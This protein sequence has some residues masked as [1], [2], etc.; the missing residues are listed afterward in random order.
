[1]INYP[2]DKWPKTEP[3]KLKI[4]S[5]LTSLMTKRNMKHGAST[6]ENPEN[7]PKVNTSSSLKIY[8]QSIRQKSILR[9]FEH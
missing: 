9:T 2:K 8:S 1:M 3:N 6:K 4:R 5:S 7:R